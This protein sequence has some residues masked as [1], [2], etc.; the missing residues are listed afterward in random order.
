M[1]KQQNWAFLQLF[2]EEPAAG[3]TLAADAGQQGDGG[4]D[5]RAENPQDAAA[6]AP[7]QPRRMTWEE[8]KADP[9]YNREIQAII[10]KR[11]SRER[12]RE[13]QPTAVDYTD[14]FR[15]LQEQG[16]AMKAVFP[17]FDL[18]RE[19]SDPAFA[20]LTA[21]DVGLGVEDAFY[22]LH[23]HQIQHAAME[24]AAQRAALRLSD[25]IRSGSRR[26]RENGGEGQ[27]ATLS[28]WDY[29]SASREEKAAL[30]KRIRDA[31]ARGEKIFPFGR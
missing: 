3:V 1:R 21:P 9:E 18:R 27:G 28:S 6:K 22:V 2:G 11:L 20:R 31:K 26:P 15:S 13:V 8:I 29:K 19:L 17:G 24:V 7:P 14:H 12:G 23:R 5:N 10:A 25:A 4:A 30:K 16:E